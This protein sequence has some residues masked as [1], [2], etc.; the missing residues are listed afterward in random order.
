ML[1]KHSLQPAQAAVSGNSLRLKRT[2]W[3]IAIGLIVLL[4]IFGRMLFFSPSEQA[5]AAANTTIQYADTHWNC[6]DPSCYSTVTAGSAQPNF[7]CAEFVSRVLSNEG[8]IPG[9]NA[10]SPQSAYQYYRASNGQMYNLLWVGW[11]SASGY[12]TIKGLY[13]YLTETGRGSD[14]GNAPSQAAPGDVTIYHEGMGHTALLVQTGSHALVDAHN[15]AHYHVE[16]T[17]G[18]DVAII[19]INS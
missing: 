17:L 15:N 11:T 9:L 7:Q 18:Y 12:N 13:Q 10:N 2:K 16:Y 8:L 19:H 5:H 1:K 6:A 4:A 14:I 3:H